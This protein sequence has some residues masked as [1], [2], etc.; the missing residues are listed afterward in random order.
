MAGNAMSINS[1]RDNDHKQSKL[2]ES[3]GKKNNNNSIQTNN[4]D[5]P[6]VNT[7]KELIQAP[8]RSEPL[9]DNA[10]KFQHYL[11]YLYKNNF[12]SL[13]YVTIYIY[14]YYLYLLINRMIYMLL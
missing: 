7:N 6:I 11:K 4:P 14:T 2:K 10:A 3:P 5:E 12:V 9:S 13:T 1:Q 8:N